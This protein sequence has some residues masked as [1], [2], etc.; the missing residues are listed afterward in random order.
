MTLRSNGATDVCVRSIDE[1]RA[2]VKGIGARLIA[3]GVD[4]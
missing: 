4:R 2:P 3:E 1:A